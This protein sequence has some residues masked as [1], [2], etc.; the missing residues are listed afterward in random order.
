MPPAEQAT[1]TAIGTSSHPAYQT[2]RAKWIDLAHVYEGSGGFLDGT[3]LVAHPREYLDHTTV[4]QV[5][6]EE[7]Q[8]DGTVIKTGRKRN[9]VKLNANPK[10]PSPKLIERRTLAKYENVAA[11]IVDQK[12]AALFRVGPTRRVAGENQAHDWLT[13]AD[14]DV[15][16][17]GT[18]LTDF[19]RD[20]WRIA[21][22]FGHAVILMDRAGGVAQP[23]TL[24][25]RGQN[26]LRLYAPIDMPD[27]RQDAAGALRE[28]KLIEMTPR[29]SLREPKPTTTRLRYVSDE[30]VEVVDEDKTGA[31]TRVGEPV[32]HG[33]GTLP[34]VILYSKRRALTPIIGQSVLGDP[35]LHIDYY[36]LDS[37]MRELLRK[38]TFSTLNV[39]LGTGE[40][41][42]SVDQAKA[43]IG[44]TIGTANVLFSGQPAQY[45]SADSANV[46]VYLA[47]K[48]AVLRTIY[49]LANMPFEADSRDAEAEG[50]LK[51]KRE[52]MNQV[53]AGYGDECERAE[54][55]IAQLWFRGTYDQGWEAKW[56]AAEPTVL[57]PDT[58][59]T[60]PLQEIFDRAKAAMAL[61][62]GRSKTF[63]LELAKQLAPL[64]LTDATPGVMQQIHAELEKLPDPEQERQARMQALTGAFEREPDDEDDPA[65]EGVPV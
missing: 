18:P 45:L 22:I 42:M 26:V 38:Q 1:A 63:M 23:V 64:L 44:E 61:P 35:Q 8:P 50:S 48:A 37:E 49:R 5:D 34:V 47:V 9:V 3:A 29:T 56:E 13:W 43:L 60:T 36:N 4:T 32:Q 2:W 14:T 31:Q 17:A 51:L 10:K 57:Y 58:F 11:P 65:K 41:A 24:A 39:P 46:T 59:D 53:L 15:D 20:A 6:E 52:D 30:T 25:E 16:G 40:G 33:F 21:A 62:L 12:L 28:V 27:W 19:M 55:A 7:A 54:L